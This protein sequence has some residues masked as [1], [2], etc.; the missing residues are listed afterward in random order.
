[1][2]LG[3]ALMGYRPAA[4]FAYFSPAFVALAH[5][6]GVTAE[7]PAEVENSLRSFQQAWARGYRYLETDVHVT[8]DGV[9]IAFH[10]D[11]LD[12]VTDAAGLVADLPWAEVAQARI[13]GQEPIPRLQDLIEALPE[14]RF[15]IDIKA[16]GAVA[17]LAQTLEHQHAGF[18]VCVGS[19]GTRRIRAFRRL[20]AGSVATAAS[21]AE[22]VRFAFGPGLRQVVPLEGQSFQVP[23]RDPR[24]GLRIITSSM[25]AAAHDRGA[26][27][28]VWTVNDTADMERL[29]ELGVDGI[30]TDNIDALQAVLQQRGLWEGNR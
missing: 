5:R 9:L 15:N 8:A 13:G 26:Q 24:T 2:A 28:H 19:F 6:G 25:I 10:D 1:M 7:T 11:R 16:A 17:P 23:E 14:A 4:D 3:W 12:R 30:V 22:I 29:I 21:P 27:V 18:R 20:T